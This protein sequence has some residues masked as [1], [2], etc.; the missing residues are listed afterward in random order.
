MCLTFVYVYILCVCSPCMIAT[1]PLT[2][3][4]KYVELLHQF[5]GNANNYLALC[6]CVVV[7][8]LLFFCIFFL[9]IFTC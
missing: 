7:F 3:G 5:K 4:R 2:T 9:L 1:I 6:S 8:L